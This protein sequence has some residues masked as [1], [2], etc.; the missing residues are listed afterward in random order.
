MK[1]RF[2][3]ED[4]DLASPSG[5]WTRT[6]INAMAANQANAALEPDLYF[7]EMA[8]TAL[9]ECLEEEIERLREERDNEAWMH[10]MCLG[11][12]EGIPGWETAK[13]ASPAIIAVKKLRAEVERLRGEKVRP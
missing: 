12:A 5:E 13:E 11:I 7:E 4:F 8:R 2:K 6:E 1:F 3:P 10:S 9:P